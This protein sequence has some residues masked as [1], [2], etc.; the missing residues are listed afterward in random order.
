[1]HRRKPF[2]VKFCL[3]EVREGH[4]PP[5]LAASDL[6]TYIYIYILV[7]FRSSNSPVPHPAHAR[8]DAGAIILD[9]APR[10]KRRNVHALRGEQQHP[11]AE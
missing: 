4:S 11:N 5:P 10:Q 9:C 6:L 1:M 3:A 2:T 7:H 8:A